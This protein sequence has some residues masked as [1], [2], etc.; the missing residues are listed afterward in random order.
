M[1]RSVSR[2]ADPVFW[3]GE[4]THS[5]LPVRVGVGAAIKGETEKRIERGKATA[6]QNKPTCGTPSFVFSPFNAPFFDAV[7]TPRI[8]ISETSLHR[9]PSTFLAVLL[10]A[11]LAAWPPARPAL[12]RHSKSFLSERHQSVF[13]FEFFCARSMATA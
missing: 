1:Q 13:L 5:P 10:D 9:C 11:C 12:P 4:R 7:V 3:A 8:T 2:F 6:P